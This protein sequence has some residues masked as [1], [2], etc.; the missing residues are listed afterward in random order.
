L[1]FSPGEEDE[2]NGQ[3]RPR[4]RRLHSDATILQ[5]NQS[6]YLYWSSRNTGE[7]TQSLLPGMKEPLMAKRDGTVMQGNTRL[8]IL[9]QR[10]VDIHSLP[11]VPF[12]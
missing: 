6:S 10:G 11:R 1:T 9:E 4:L 5:S 12:P 7:I 2:E 8:L 3:S